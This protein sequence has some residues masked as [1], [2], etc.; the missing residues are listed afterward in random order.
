[1]EI[2][3]KY[4]AKIDVDQICDKAMNGKEA[5]EAVMKDVEIIHN[6]K[7]C[8]YELIFMDCN[9]PVIDGYSAT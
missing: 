9:M 1:M 5:L 8:S 7:D 4:S 2:I 6:Y 3:L